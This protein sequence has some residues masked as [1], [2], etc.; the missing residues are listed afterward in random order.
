VLEKRSIQALMA[1]L[2]F[3]PVSGQ[4]LG[5]PSPLRANKISSCFPL[6]TKIV[7]LISDRD[8][9]NAVLSPDRRDTY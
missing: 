6:H 1:N 9:Y 7:L 2:V 4:H 3:N 5:G 8:H